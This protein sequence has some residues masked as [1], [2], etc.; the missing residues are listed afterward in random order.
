MPMVDFSTKKKVLCYQDKQNQNP[1][2]KRTF[3]K[4]GVIAG[5]GAILSGPAMASRSFSGPKTPDL[6][7]FEQ[8]KLSYSYDALEPYIDAKTMELHYSKHHAGYTSKF[9]AALKEELVKSGSPEEI[10]KNVSKRSA[11]IRNNG[12]G[13]YNHN[14]YW[15]N[16][17]P[18]G[19]KAKGAFLKMLEKEFGSFDKFQDDFSKAAST[20]FGSG[21]AWLISQNGKLKITQ[22]SN[23]D[24]PLMD[25]A[26]D[27][28]FPLLGIDVWEHAYYL[29]YQNRR[30]E[31]IS[32]FMRLIDW[33]FVEKRYE[34]A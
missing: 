16:M 21:W 11:S 20:V 30:T 31:Y 18:G 6:S 19:N 14:L 9:N 23:Q 33:S 15:Q 1:M 7:E 25:V 27:Q 28:G 29:N 13:W 8:Q 3:L 12:G 2:D 5:A 34:M 10:F 22:T 32:A 24:N 26:A 17:T 4:T